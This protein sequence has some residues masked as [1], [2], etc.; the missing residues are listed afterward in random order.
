MLVG[1]VL[2][3]EASMPIIEVG[4]ICTLEQDMAINI[5]IGNV[6][7]FLFGLSFCM[8]SM[9]LI[10]SGVAAPL[11]PSRFAEIFIDT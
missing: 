1:F 4:R 2:P 3:A 8:D 9:A 5:I 6:M 10:P 7:T 11:I